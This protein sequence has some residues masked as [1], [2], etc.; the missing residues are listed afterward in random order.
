[1]E[2]TSQRKQEQARAET[3]AEQMKR[4]TG[5]NAKAKEKAQVAEAADHRGGHRGCGG[6]RARSCLGGLAPPSAG[7]IANAA[8][9]QELVRCSV[10]GQ[11]DRTTHRLYLKGVHPAEGEI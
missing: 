6:L 10:S 3:P 11:R 9:R 4:E 1:M 2:M 7:S 8:A 5:Q